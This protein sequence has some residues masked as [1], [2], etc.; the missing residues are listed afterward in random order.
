MRVTYIK[1]G[2]GCDICDKI[3]N[4][5]YRINFGSYSTEID[6]CEACAKKLQKQIGHALEK[7]AKKNKENINMSKNGRQDMKMAAVQSL[8]NRGLID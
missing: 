4:N 6:L 2:D 3:T 8:K 1:S 7:G 5:V